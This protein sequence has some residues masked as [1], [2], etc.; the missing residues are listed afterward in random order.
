MYKIVYENAEEKRELF[1]DCLG[2]GTLMGDAS[3]LEMALSLATHEV[4]TA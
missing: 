4:C 1:A 2:F 3:L